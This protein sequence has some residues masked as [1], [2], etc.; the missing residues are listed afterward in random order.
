MAIRL[1]GLSPT[2]DVGDSFSFN[3]F[4][5]R[6]VRMICEQVLEDTLDWTAHE[7]NM[8]RD[9]VLTLATRLAGF[10]GDCGD[11]EFTTTVGET[12]FEVT[13]QKLEEFIQFLRACEGFESE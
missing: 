13:R 11:D 8:D 6:P 1:A 7:A 12:T 5:W 9:E 3:G 10:L 4:E 2:S